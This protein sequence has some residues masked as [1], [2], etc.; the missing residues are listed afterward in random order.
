[1]TNISIPQKISA[2][3]PAATRSDGTCPSIHPRVLSAMAVRHWVPHPV[4][5]DGGRTEKSTALCFQTSNLLPLQVRSVGMEMCFVNMISPGDKVIVC[6]NSVFGARM[7]EMLSAAGVRR[8][9]EDRWGSPVDPQ[10]VE[11]ALKRT[12]CQN[13][14]SFMPRRRPVLCQMQRPCAKSR[15]A[16]IV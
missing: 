11:D 15:S 9:V 7:I 12:R 14:R 1:M 8:R 2:F 3:L 5:T 13:R 16:T 6:R 10:K 4:F